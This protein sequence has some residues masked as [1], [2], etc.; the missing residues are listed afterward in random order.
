MFDWL[1]I[2]RL[3][4]GRPTDGLVR[5][6]E[7]GAN[8]DPSLRPLADEWLATL[9]SALSEDNITALLGAL[10]TELENIKKLKLDP[11]EH[12]SDF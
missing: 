5:L 2:L 4:S 10:P 3:G 9:A 8:A 7:A 6:I 1:K 11:R 12:P